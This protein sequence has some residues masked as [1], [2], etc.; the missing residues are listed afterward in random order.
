MKPS[1]PAS[2]AGCLGILLSYILTDSSSVS[3]V[4]LLSHFLRSYPGNSTPVPSP[5]SQG[6]Q[7]STDLV[8]APSF[9]LSHDSSSW[10]PCRVQAAPK[11]FHTPFRWFYLH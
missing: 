10:R 1:H 6:R 9:L 2:R 7:S 5:A 11:R 4:E 8:P 3:L